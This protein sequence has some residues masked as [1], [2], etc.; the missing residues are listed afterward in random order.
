M[1]QQKEIPD[2]ALHS[3]FSYLFLWFLLISISQSFYFLVLTSSKNTGQLFCRISL[4]LSCLI[5]STWFSMAPYIVDH[6]LPLESSC[7]WVSLIIPSS[8]FSISSLKSP[9]KSCLQALLLLQCGPVSGFCLES[10]LLPSVQMIP[11]PL[12]LVSS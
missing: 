1:I 6:S 12:N 2:H 4:N 10:F 11:K 9:C 8:G 5:T 7:S 3:Q